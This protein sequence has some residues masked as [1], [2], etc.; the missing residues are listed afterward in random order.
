LPETA[1]ILILIAV[2]LPEQLLKIVSQTIDLLLASLKA[3][4]T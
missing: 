1:L 2:D 4:S 3:L